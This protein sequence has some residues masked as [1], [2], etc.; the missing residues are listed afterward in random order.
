MALGKGSKFYMGTGDTLE[1]AV[2]TKADA[3]ANLQSIG[4]QTTS[5]DEVETTDLDSGKFKEFDPTLMDNGSFPITGLIKNDNYATLKG[6]EG[7]KRPF[8]IYHPELDE[9]NGKFMG[10]ISELTRGEIT[11][12]EHVTFSATIRISGA[13]EDFEEPIE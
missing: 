7:I 5:T 13:I 6:N 12:S 3:I 2:F 11:P 9:L 4:E 10:W 1:T 8:A